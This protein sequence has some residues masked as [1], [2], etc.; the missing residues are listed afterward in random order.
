[1]TDTVSLLRCAVTTV[2]TVRHLIEPEI[3]DRMPIA[4]IETSGRNR[5]ATGL[6]TTGTKL[7]DARNAQLTVRMARI[8]LDVL[9]TAR[10]TR[11]DLSVPVTGPTTLTVPRVL[12]IVLRVRTVHSVRTTVHTVPIVRSSARESVRTG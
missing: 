7:A 8:D 3:A 1:M 9:E 5:G 2:R 12:L 11:I 6:T 4:H 10:T